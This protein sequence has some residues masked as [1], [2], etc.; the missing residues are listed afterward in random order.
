MR[1][2]EERGGIKKEGSRR[3]GTTGKGGNRDTAEVEALAVAG[4]DFRPVAGGRAGMEVTAE[5]SETTEAAASLREED[6]AEGEA[7]EEGRGGEE[8]EEW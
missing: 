8:A 4:L 7:E 3:A 1:G 5:A 6:G 2:P